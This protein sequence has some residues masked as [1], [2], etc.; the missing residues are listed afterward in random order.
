VTIEEIATLIED[1]ELCLDRE[2]YDIINTKLEELAIGD[3]PNTDAHEFVTWLRCT[4]MW[5]AKLSNWEPAVLNAIKVLDSRGLDGKY[6]LRGLDPK[7]GWD[8]KMMWNGPGVAPLSAPSEDIWK[9]RREYT[10]HLNEKDWEA[11]NKALDAPAKPNEAL[12]KLMKGE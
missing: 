3:H 11:F 12:K 2:W 6:L 1:I 7:E 9:M 4:F 8:E 5:R 10:Y